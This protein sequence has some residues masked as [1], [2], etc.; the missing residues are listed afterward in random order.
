M[1][2]TTHKCI[3][4]HQNT[5]QNSKKKHGKALNYYK[6]I[7]YQ[8]SQCKSCFY[9]VLP[10]KLQDVRDISEPE[11]IFGAIGPT[12]SFVKFL[13]AVYICRK[14]QELLISNLPKAK[15]LVLVQITF[16]A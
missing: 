3:K 10:F 15:I 16:D 7:S 6:V 4:R 9:P 1:M 11:L 8:F 14:H 2:R 12:G 5:L 13:S